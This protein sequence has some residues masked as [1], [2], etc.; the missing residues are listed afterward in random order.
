M[1]NKIKQNKKN[2]NKILAQFR[3]TPSWMCPNTFKMTVML[4]WQNFFY[5]ERHFLPCHKRGTKKKFW[6]ESN[7]NPEVSIPHED[8][9]FFLFLRSWLDE[10]NISP[11]FFTE[12]KNLLSFSVYKISFYISYFAFILNG[13]FFK[14][15]TGWKRSV[16]RALLVQNLYK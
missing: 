1:K 12:L 6:E 5:E 9:E 10:K 4:A 3:D 16:T 7:L 15:E 8:S 13:V 11:Y 2:R 14:N